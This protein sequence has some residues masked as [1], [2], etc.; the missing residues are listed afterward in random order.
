M[1]DHSLEEH[2]MDYYHG[3]TI[4]G[5]HE[6]R[7]YAS[8]Y[9]NLKDPV[10][11]LTTSRQLALHYIWDTNRLTIKMPMLD[12]RKDGIL[13]FQEMFPGALEYFYKGV[14]GYIYHCVGDY[15][16]NE[17]TGVFTCAT[18]HDPVPITD[19]EYV[20][21]VHTKILEY[22]QRGTFIYEKYESLPQY[23]YD[24][25]RGVIMRM[26]KKDNLLQNETHPYWKF[27]QEKFPRYWKEAIVLYQHDLL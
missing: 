27:F 20:D 5:L 18:S 8:P 15:D 4:A 26:I 6:L 3:T 13:V 17:A 9:A 2:F 7:P 24:I 12:I 21:D 11:Y 16:V 19:Y 25:I 10:I 22:E 23:R 14:S 1:S